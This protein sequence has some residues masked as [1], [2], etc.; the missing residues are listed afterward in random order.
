MYNPGC[1]YSTCAINHTSI[2]VGRAYTISSQRT[3]ARATRDCLHSNIFGG[4][5]SGNETSGIGLR[6]EGV[7]YVVILHF[8][9]PRVKAMWLIP[10]IRSPNLESTP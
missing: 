10:L 3:R 8:R 7:L 9:C 6:L 2:D 1:C 5:N 4:I